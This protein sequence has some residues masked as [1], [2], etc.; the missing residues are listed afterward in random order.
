MSQA[1][2][3]C[4]VA[5]GT[6]A[7]VLLFVGTG[8]G[9][10]TEKSLVTGELIGKLA[11][12]GR[13]DVDLHAVF[14]VSRTF[15]KD[16]ALHWY[17]CGYSGGGSHN[18]VGGSFGD[19]GLHVPHTQRDEK[20][21]RCVTTPESPAV[22][23]DGNDIMKGNFAVED[24][25]ADSKDMALEVWVRDAKPSKGEAI[26]GWQSEDGEETSAPL[27]YPAT[28]SGSDKWSHIVVNCKAATE[29]WYLDGKEVSSG[30]RK[31]I[32]GKGHR[33][34]LGGESVSKPSFDGDLAV[35]RLHEE[36]LSDEEIAHNFQGG[37]MLGTELHSWW[38]TEKDKWWA[39]E[40]AHFRHCVDKKEMAA[41][42]EKET[43]RFHERVPTM[44]ELAEKLYHLYSE[45]LAL[46]VG[47]VSSKPEY[48]G[49]G[50]KYKIPIQPSKGSWMGW[51]GK[52]GFGW[53]CQGA[54]HINPH[55]LVHGCQGQTGGAMQGNYW[56]AHANFPQTYAG[57][58]QTLPPTCCARVCMF[59]PANGRCYYHARLMF[60]HLAQTPE[61]G[62]MFISKL[63][64]DAGTETEK[65]EYPWQAFAR[66]DPDPATPLA[67]EWA[68]MVQRC[69]TW[70][71]EI[72]GGQPDDLYKQDAARGRDEILRYGRVLLEPVPYEEGWWRPPME[73]APQQ[74]GWNICPL[75]IVSDEAAAELS[76]Y[77]NKERGSDW[78]AGFVGV[79][80]AGKPRY[81]KIAGVGE[82]L[83]FKVAE[84]TKELYLVVCATPT[85]VMAIPMTGDFR[86][87][88]Q[89]RF[90]YKVRL[91]GCEP[92][93]VL[94][95]DKPTEA[96]AQH[97]NGGGFVTSIAH[98][99]PTAYV[100][101]QAQ[102]LGR[103]KVLGH[104]RIEDYAV[105]KD[106]ATVRDHARVSG[107]A[108][109][110]G[111]ATIRD[112]AKLRDYAAVTGNTVVRDNARILQHAYTDAGCSEVYGNATLKGV[113][114]VG[115]RVGGSAILDGHYRK[116]NLIDKGAWFTW[117]WAIGH[118][119]GE[120]DIELGGL[121]AQYLF[122]TQHPVFAWDTYG[123]THAILHGNPRTV[124]YPDRK[125]SKSCSYVQSYGRKQKV[126]FSVQ[127]SGTAL[128]LNGRDQF[129]EL[130][131]GVA[132]LHD[133]S[134]VVTL[135]HQGG[136]PN[137]RL[138]EFAADAKTRMHLTH[139]DETGRP[140]FLITR[141]GKTQ[142]LRSSAP[143]P[144]GK[145]AELTLVLT[146]DT[147]I[148]QIDGKTVARDGGITLNPD[149]LRATACLVGRGLD[150]DFFAGEL[151]DV[152][153]Y[154]VPLVDEEAPKPDPAEWAI[155]PILV[156]DSA[157]VMH[158]APGKDPLGGVEYLFEE[159]TDSPGGD[160]S[161]WQKSPVFRDEGLRDGSRYTYRLK[162]RDVHGNETK[163]S[164]ASDLVCTRP[165]A[166]IQSADRDGLVV[167]EAE[168]FARNV[169]APDG[170]EWKL[171]TARKGYGGSGAMKAL[172]D[173]RAQHDGDFAARSPRMD[174][175]IE[176]AR[177]GRHWLWV[178]GFGSNPNTDSIHV[179]LD[180]EPGDWGQ[181]V[182]TGS[183]KYIWM[184]HPRPLDVP[185][186]GVHTLSIWMREDGA[187][188]DRILLTGRP[189]F[190]V[191]GER[192][193]TSG[194]T[195]GVGPP[196]SPLR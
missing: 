41:W 179:G 7:F 194:G 19:F 131:R 123:A 61:Y 43:A 79:D 173:R 146:G 71:F 69:V 160:G 74:L 9:V 189:E 166:F 126:E 4:R 132:D 64:Y 10:E 163:W 53:A 20:Y 134:I 59:F 149:D 17:N 158:A 77:V 56:E 124:H 22:R 128:A 138:V 119:P 70:D 156:T 161:G 91:T 118:N 80:A 24:A 25:A 169:A 177:K 76:G 137:Q 187:L 92:L 116:S 102:V 174:Y 155:A 135:K 180:L 67:Y 125:A 35:V 185:A 168:H 78:R 100:G 184:K 99:D 88:E 112:H 46:R 38:R 72:F 98:A 195:L 23:F 183:G 140:A 49:D 87:P 120:H 16:T 97:P 175:V 117:S 133:L 14:M 129:L 18:Q 12:A 115:G 147:G 51:D 136:K 109:V 196:E 89:E 45:R 114:G 27:T 145:W 142:T 65:N 44:F 178:R 170:H 21:P 148:L 96:G 73:M 181:N 55:E 95:P 2:P 154:S 30:P 110:S 150:G 75:K 40:S 83:R 33:M 37:I 152:S 42:D 60:E 84:G 171:D 159:T 32:I 48:R 54:G 191:E 6:V 143:I 90:P 176:F 50:I 144:S 34:V 106:S 58:Y 63:W 85:K 81:G 122:E 101:P 157:A 113:A 165:K 39:E 162:M 82:T 190:K 105:V 193:P 57:V 121:Y 103:A 86:S 188:I 13:L 68:R 93:D 15:E 26:L 141:D 164:K 104:A 186:P 3:G 167:I 52:L 111:D 108:V 1:M 127:T 29:T 107:H 66:F 182:Q 11:V 130:P 36:P 8:M 153:I 28:F 139:A 62:P 5:T 47:V 151:E 192:D 172:P 31:M 94:I